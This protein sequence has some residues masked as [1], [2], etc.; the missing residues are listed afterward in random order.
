[1]R[2]SSLCCNGVRTPNVRQRRPRSR[3]S[4]RRAPPSTAGTPSRHADRT[5]RGGPHGTTRRLDTHTS[6]SSR[7]AAERQCRSGNRVAPPRS[8]LCSLPLSCV[9][10]CSVPPFCRAAAAEAAGGGGACIR[11]LFPKEAQRRGERAT[12]VRQASGVRAPAQWRGLRFSLKS[13]RRSMTGI[14]RCFELAKKCAARL[15]NDHLALIR[16]SLQHICITEIERTAQ[17]AR[18]E[19][20]QRS[21]CRHLRRCVIVRLDSSTL[22]HPPLLDRQC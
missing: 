1:M 22:P 21:V 20:T 18:A 14:T 17:I 2:G 9:V 4:C 3:C 10:T 15:Q 16:A 8:P 12:R 5:T 19:S 11:P 6:E 13:F 7:V